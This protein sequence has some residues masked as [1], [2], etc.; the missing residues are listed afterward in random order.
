EKFK[1]L[2]NKES[3]L[4]DQQSQQHERLDEEIKNVLSLTAFEE[5]KLAKG[6]LDERQ[7]TE[8]VKSTIQSGKQLREQHSKLQKQKERLL[9]ELKRAEA[10]LRNSKDELSSATLTFEKLQMK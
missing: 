8:A 9:R 4:L 10:Q 1:T 5:A 7:S 6:Q 2:S 3:K